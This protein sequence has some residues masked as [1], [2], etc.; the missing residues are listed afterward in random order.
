MKDL[1]YDI[2]VVGGGPAGSTTAKF[3]AKNGANVLMIEKR[4]EIGVPVRCGEGIAKEGLDSVGIKASPEWVVMEMEGARIVSPKGYTM[5]LSEKVAGNEVGYNVR[6][7]LFDKTLARDAAKAGADIMVKTSAT[8]IIKKDGVIKGVKAKH[9]GENFNINANIVVGADGFE[10]QVGRWGGID[11]TLKLSDIN[12]CLQYLLVGVDVDIRYNDFHLGAKRAPGGYLWV[13]PRSEDS[14]NVGIGVN[15]KIIKDLIKSNELS[16]VPAAAKTYLDKFI[17][18]Q[19]ALAKGKPIAQIAGAVSCCLPL[20]QILT[21]GLM[22]VGDAGRMIDPL[23]GGGVVPSCNAGKIAGEVAAEAVKQNEFSAEFL[24][25]YD[26]EWRA[27]YENHMIR[28]W[29]AKEKLVTLS[30]DIFDKVLETLQDYEVEQLTTFG[31]LNAVKAKH[32]ELVKEFEDLL[33]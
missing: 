25:T 31:I 20:D 2:V 6:R 33:M 3:A 27:S 11:T 5:V 28:N 15:L 18:S 16:S 22:L 9:M 14:A 13:F 21:D 19:P 26:K 4:Q 30:D 10:S 7:D 24:Q 8:D 32:P 1:N 12:T 29:I 23:S 17:Q